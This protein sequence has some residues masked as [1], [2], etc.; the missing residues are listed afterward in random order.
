MAKKLDRRQQ[1][2]KNEPDKHSF[3]KNDIVLLFENTEYK[4]AECIKRSELAKLL[5]ET[6]AVLKDNPKAKVIRLPFY[7]VYVTNVET[8]LAKQDRIT[9]MIT[10]AGTYTM[11]NTVDQAEMVSPIFSLLPADDKNREVKAIEQ[12]TESNQTMEG[13]IRQKKFDDA[14]DLYFMMPKAK[15]NPKLRRK[16]TNLLEE[17]IGDDIPNQFAMSLFSELFESEQLL[18][19]KKSG[20][21]DLEDIFGK[22]K[23]S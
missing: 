17:S 19:P 1:K 20:G 4:N 6:R 9:F 23:L 22:I 15:K 14:L 11:L 18:K 13:L 12:L 8:V 16:L 5:S 7:K 10:K 3:D 2:C 21:D